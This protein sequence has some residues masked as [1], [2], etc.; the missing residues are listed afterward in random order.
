MT[1]VSVNALQQLIQQWLDAE[2]GRSIR[3]LARRGGFR[4]PSTL[5]ALM[6]RDA[7]ASLPRKETLRKLAHGLEQPMATV[8]SAAAEAAGFRAEKLDGES[9]EV[10]AWLALLGDLP[11]SKR[12][13]LWEIGRLYLRR[14]KDEA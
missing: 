7:P 5:H 13:E 10:Q 14:L 3:D 9:Q 8:E 4:S 6:A 2:P 11:E 12:Q 1:I